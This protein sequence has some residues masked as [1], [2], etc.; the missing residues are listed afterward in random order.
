MHKPLSLG[1]AGCGC[2][3]HSVAGSGGGA[4]PHL[5]LERDGRGAV[6]RAWSGWGG[7]SP[8]KAAACLSPSLASCVWVVGTLRTEPER[9][10]EPKGQWPRQR[11]VAQDLPARALTSQGEEQGFSTPGSPVGAPG[12]RA[13]L[14]YQWRWPPR[15]CRQSGTNRLFGITCIFYLAWQR[16]SASSNTSCSPVVG[17]LLCSRRPR[18]AS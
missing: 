14:P 18:R 15:A 2:G 13:Q 3:R 8:Q 5:L 11:R 17:T 10:V 4:R 9:A 16:P 1:L 6:S 7:V 12:G